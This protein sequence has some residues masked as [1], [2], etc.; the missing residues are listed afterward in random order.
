MRKPATYV[1]PEG[2]V[3]TAKYFLLGEQPGRTEVKVRRPFKGPAGRELDDC[4]NVLRIPRS[5]CY[6]RN[7]CMDLDV[8]ISKRMQIRG[9]GEI[10]YDGVMLGYME[11]LRTDLTRF[12]GKVAIAIGGYA[13]GALTGRDGI[14]NWRGSIIPYP[15]IPTISVLPTLHPATIIPPKNVYLNKILIQYDIKK[16]KDIV[17]GNYTPT[18][19]QL[20]VAPSFEDSI[21]YLG[22]IYE[23]GKAGRTIDYDIELYNEELSCI[24]FSLSPQGETR[25][26]I[27]IPF[28]GPNGDYFIPPQETDILLR[29]ARIL[30]DTSIR[31]RGQNLVFD[32][33]FLLR[34]YGIKVRNV[35]DTMVA[36]R[37]LM[38][39]F[40]VGLDFITSIWT[41]HPYYKADGKKF[42]EGKSWSKKG[43]QYNATDAIIP[44]EAFPKQEVELK[45]RGNWPTYVRQVK[46]LEPLAYMM[47]RGTR[48]DLEGIGREYADSDIE[49]HE[50]CENLN[51]EAGTT[52]NPNSPKQLIEY[53]YGRLKHK[54]YKS[55]KTGKDTTDDIAM[56][57]LARKGI[58]EAGFVL[59]AR[60]LRKRMGTYLKPSIFDD[61][62]RLR[63]SYNPVGTMFSRFSSAKNIFGSGM[64]RQ[65][66]PS[67][68]NQYLL[69]DE[70]Y[71]Y[72]SLDLAQAENRIVAYVGNII[73]MI[74][75]FESDMDL[76][77]LTAA[78]IFSK[79]Y[80]EISDEPGTSPFGNPNKS[81]RDDGKTANHS[82]NYDLGYRSFAL[83]HLMEERDGRFIV[84]RY[85]LAYPGIR[86]V[87]HKYVVNQLSKNRTL[88][89]LKGRRTMLLEKW[90]DKLFKCGYSCIPQG[91]VGDIINENGLEYVY[92]N[93]DKFEE[94]ELLDQIHDSL[95]FQIPLD[96]GWLRIAEILNDVKNNLEET[97]TF[98]S[99]DFIIPVDLTFGLNLYKKHCQEIS[100]KDWPNSTEELARKLEGLWKNLLASRKDAK[101]KQ[102]TIACSAKTVESPD[103]NAGQM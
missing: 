35:D 101:T 33:H 61:D 36:Q 75:A 69:P 88:V 89:N 77:R 56:R 42:F 91:T 74:D 59:E 96:V 99:R 15:H 45:K 95:G 103:D 29:I 16:A 87:Y 13:L 20:I 47:E 30:E 12:S 10:T 40:N 21:K 25:R 48:A 85:H 58:K 60:R 50:V 31:K 94:V 27:S 7:T 3:E 1:K 79:P 97:L 57:R 81:E 5:E 41:D 84:E 38:P 71:G 26:A 93:D 86:N 37:I 34:K 51:K 24:S 17:E 65:N 11:E 8:H 54:A 23:E 72:F 55:R 76:H 28:V 18:K 102:T 43:W 2:N 53:F 46:T 78:L 100:Y 32:S 73:P 92:Y 66:W 64:N 49:Y 63:C 44:Q 90:G 19:R 39:E 98:N 83:E 6:I 9:E 4:L 80:A 68:L 52:L 67:D 22:E 82:L 70:G 62:G 14:T